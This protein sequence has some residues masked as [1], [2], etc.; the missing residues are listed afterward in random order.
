MWFDFCKLYRIDI[1][2]RDKMTRL[3]KKNELIEWLMALENDV[4]IDKIDEIKK[5]A[6]YNFENNFE[7]G[8]KLEAFRTEI[9]KR[10]N[11]YNPD[12]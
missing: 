7:K 12:E 6:T 1:K 5:E 8:L 2:Y 9:K 11:N 10:I 3:K 4:T